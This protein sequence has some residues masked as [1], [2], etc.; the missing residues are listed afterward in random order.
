LVEPN[1]DFEQ[2]FSNYGV[3]VIAP[4]ANRLT[5]RGTVARGAITAR[6]AGFVD[7]TFFE[8]EETQKA[9]QFHVSA[10]VWIG[11]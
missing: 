5:L 4:V 11:R 6:D 3:E 10:T 1:D 8:I 7:F 2:D 9:W